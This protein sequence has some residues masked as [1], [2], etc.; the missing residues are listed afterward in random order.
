MRLLVTLPHQPQVREE[1]A[2]L[3][4]GHEDR[5]P[6]GLRTVWGA[7]TA[8][9]A[10]WRLV[11][12]RGHSQ[13]AGGW[14]YTWVSRPCKLSSTCNPR[15]LSDVFLE[16]LNYSCRLLAF[17]PA[18][19]EPG[20][21]SS[22]IPTGSQA[23][24]L[25]LSSYIVLFFII[26]YSEQWDGSFLRNG[27]HEFYIALLLHFI[28]THLFKRTFLIHFIIVI[29]SVIVLLSCWEENKIFILYKLNLNLK[30]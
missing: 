14:R 2:E 30:F 23:L 22:G 3:W 13:H 9:V 5:D 15:K 18:A 8:E 27:F 19:S 28:T 11:L 16:S 24:K 12:G 25:L 10:V 17:N 6:L 1:A 4:H 26:F 21:V 29:C 20:P 7:G